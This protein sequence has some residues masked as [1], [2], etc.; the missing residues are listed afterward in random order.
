MNPH[1]FLGQAHF[2]VPFGLD[3]PSENGA[4]LRRATGSETKF[5]VP[6]EWCGTAEDGLGDDGSQSEN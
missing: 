6:V 4:V 2:E 5:C 3:L 1:F